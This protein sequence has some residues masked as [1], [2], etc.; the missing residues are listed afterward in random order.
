M[1]DLILASGSPRRQAFLAAL[2]LRFA[3]DVADVDENALPGETPP[4]LVLRLSRAKARTVAARHHDALVLAADTVVVL[5]DRILGKPVGPEDAARMLAALRGRE[6]QV[7]TA[8]SL[9]CAPP[10]RFPS[11]LGGPV[12]PAAGGCPDDL[13]EP[14]AHLCRSQVWMRDYS[15]AEIQAYVASGDPLDKAG[16]Y[17]IQHPRFA[18]VARWAGC[19]ASIMGLPLG[20]AGD[21]LRAAGVALPVELAAVCEASSGPGACCLRRS[22]RKC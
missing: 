2:G 13:P 16:A 1:Q 4:A 22:P 11:A 6:H 20:L 21:L 3:V 10:G 12:D 18:P 8:V 9:A 14:P 5:D 15:D 7:Y 19:Y 17:A